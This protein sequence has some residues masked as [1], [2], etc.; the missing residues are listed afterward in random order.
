MFKFSKGVRGYSLGGLCIAWG[1]EVGVQI[2]LSRLRVIVKD[3]VRL[4]VVGYGFVEI[5]RWRV[6]AGFFNS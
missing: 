6:S 5:I 2:S 3:G 1:G 4:F